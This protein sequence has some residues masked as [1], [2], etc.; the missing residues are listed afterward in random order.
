MIDPDEFLEGNE[1]P[2]PPNEQRRVQYQIRQLETLSADR[3]GA[4]E[5]A[6][7]ILVLAEQLAV[8]N[9]QFGQWTP[10]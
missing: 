3:V 4:Y 10:R 9:D 5:I 1:P 2:A 7:A 6:K 8:F